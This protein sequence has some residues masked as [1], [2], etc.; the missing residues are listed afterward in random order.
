M[1][2][3]DGLK[4]PGLE[5]FVPATTRVTEQLFRKFRAFQ[6]FPKQIHWGIGLQIEP[7]AKGQG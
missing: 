2:T 7:C 3:K 5:K 4:K 6:R 1:K